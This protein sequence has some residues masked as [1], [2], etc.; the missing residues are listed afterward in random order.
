MGCLARDDN[1]FGSIRET[2]PRMEENS[3]EGAGPPI[4]LE[5]DYNEGMFPS[6]D[7]QNHPYQA[8]ENCC[9]MIEDNPSKVDNSTNYA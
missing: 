8:D 5:E 7:P 9:I 3:L 6:L 1:F 2:L 4:L